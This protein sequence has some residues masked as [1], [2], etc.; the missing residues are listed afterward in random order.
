MKHRRPET[1]LSRRVDQPRAWSVHR[2]ALVAMLL[3]AGRADAAPPPDADPALS[4]WFR[5]LQA[6]DT[7]QS[8]CSITDCRPTETRTRDNH[9]EVLIGDRW[10]MVP[11][12]K[13]LSR[14]DNPTGRA[15]VCWT[16]SLGIMCF[17]HGPEG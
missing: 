9:Y 7:G 8:C 6:P 1:C 15:V 3:F 5:G 14:S 2:L 13:I 10:L 4:P 11:P 16:P 12:E 17:V